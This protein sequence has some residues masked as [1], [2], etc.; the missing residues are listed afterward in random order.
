MKILL[1]RLSSLG[2]LVIMTSLLEYLKD[3]GEITLITKKKYFELFEKDPRVSRLV[4]EKNFNAIKHEKFDIACDLHA[5]PK[6]IIKLLKLRASK[7][8]LINKRAIQRRL[9]V[10]FKKDIKEV[11]LYKLYTRPFHRFFEDHSYPIPSINI[12]FDESLRPLKRYI[13]VFPGASQVSKRWPLEYFLE[14]SRMVYEK[15][16]I[17]SVY[18]GAEDIKLPDAPYVA[19][20]MGTKPLSYIINTEKFATFVLSNDSGP[21]HIA[22][23]VNTPLFVIF[24][25]TIPEFGFRPV[26]KAPVYLFERKDLSCRPCSLH[27]EKKCKYGDLRCLRGITPS[28]VLDKIDEFFKRYNSTV[29]PK[30]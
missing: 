20:L 1:I 5:K 4:D 10:W 28:I 22:A 25:P 29:S 18:L 15:Y 19:D 11:P 2:D 9:S 26:S 21:A 30:K 23:A 6:T 12:P 14:V 13:A 7:K 17:P 8:C 24:G 16:S 3:K 27:G